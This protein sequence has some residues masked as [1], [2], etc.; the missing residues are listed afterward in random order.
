MRQPY[1]REHYIPTPTAT[2][3]F[4]RTFLPWQVLRFAWINL[5]M[6]RMIS[7]GHHGR[8][9]LRPIVW[10]EESDSKGKSPVKSR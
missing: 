6:V 1:D 9:P 3:Q 7:I 2:T 5:K 4:F 8:A 10:P